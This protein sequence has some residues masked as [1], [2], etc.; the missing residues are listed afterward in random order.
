MKRTIATLIIILIA[1][2]VYWFMLKT[3][4]PPP[5]EAK[6]APITLKKHSDSF[7]NSINTVVT[8]YL[9]IKD[10]FVEADTAAAKLKAAAFILSLSNIDT[11]ELKKDTA[12]VF[13]TVLATISDV[14]ANAASLIN[15]TDITEMRRDFS[16]LTDMMYPTFFKAIEYEGPKLYLENCPMAFNDEVPANWISNSAEIVNPYLGKKHPKYKGGMINCGEV[17]DSIIAK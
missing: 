2:C 7:N 1:F 13:E 9:G 15:Q 16:S 6:V 5:K 12:M 3:K 4:T 10:A 14:R 17:K 8:D 11:V